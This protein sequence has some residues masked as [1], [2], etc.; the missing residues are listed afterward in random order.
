MT[1]GSTVM[2]Q[3]PSTTTLP[4]IRTMMR[5]DTIAAIATPP[6]TAGLAVIRISGPAAITRTA[7]VFRGIDLRDAPSHTV[8]LGT[9]V[10]DDGGAID[11]VLATVFRAPHSYTGD[12]IVELGCHG[13]SAVSRAVLER[14][15]DGGSREGLR[16]AEPGEFTRRAFLNG[17]MDLAQAEAVADLI[18]AQT[19]E[20][21]AASMMQLE[22]ALSRH[23]GALRDRLVRC[24]SLL[25]LAL[26]F[27]EEDV[28]LLS[29]EELRAELA[30]VADAVRLLLDGYRSGRVIRDGFRV[31][32]AGRPN[33]GKSSVL[34]ALVGSDRAIVTDIPGTTRDYIEEAVVLGGVLV[35]IIDTAGLR[36]SDDRVEQ[37]GM[38]RTEAVIR[39][40]DL[41]VYVVDATEAGVFE[42][43]AQHRDAR[44]AGDAVVLL[45]KCDLVDEA[46]R[47][48]LPL[49]EGVVHGSA[50]MPAGLDALAALVRARAQAASRMSE[51]G[52]MLVTNARHAD[53]LHR[54]LAGVERS[55]AAINAGRTEEYLALD[56]RAAID[57][58]GEVVGIVR[59]DDVLEAIFSR[60]CIGK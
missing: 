5:A 26:D 11:Q 29:R 18:H 4:E 49:E 55:L 43:L 25:E 40:A 13:G 15:L 60:F 47:R 14:L 32:L 34:N 17:R 7:E 33:A 1:H 22:G 21:R 59:T 10:G 35:R 36:E 12:D 16:H 8:H 48:A 41:T 44:D 46:A 37:L 56:L 45:N 52:A 2:L 9:V 39:S 23:V 54:A 53:C 58:A 20:A 28:E 38:A 31:A 42:H 30:A 3:E 50:R 57:A 24:A 27:A 6:G 51:Q 19:D